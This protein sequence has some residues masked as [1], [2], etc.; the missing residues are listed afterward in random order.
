MLKLGKPVSL[1][2]SYFLL[3]APTG[4]SSELRSSSVDLRQIIATLQPKL[5]KKSVAALAKAVSI[6]KRRHDCDMPTDTLLAIAFTE[7]SL[8]KGKLGT[9]NPNTR[10]YGLMQINEEMVL[11]LHLDRDKL[12]KDEAYNLQIGCKILT[13]NRKSYAETVPYWL[14]LYRAGVA[15]WRKKV[16]RVALAYDRR[17]RSKAEEISGIGQS[18]ADVK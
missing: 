12:L 16:R 3:A 14:G 7:S 11:R 18:I 10:D 13:Q 1:A 4:Q 5:S 15:V 17:I 8:F 6:V 9:M 2:I